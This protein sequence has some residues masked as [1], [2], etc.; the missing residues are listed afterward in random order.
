LKEYDKAIEDYDKAIE[1]NPKYASAHF[2]L[3][4][5]YALKKEEGDKSKMLEYL[6]KAI[7]LDDKY[8]KDAKEDE[9]FKKYLK[10]PDFKKLVE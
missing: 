9:D 10:N 8:K 6:K 4:C 7:K 1:I 5:V 2:N 3:A